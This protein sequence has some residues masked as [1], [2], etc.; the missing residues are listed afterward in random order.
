VSSIFLQVCNLGQQI[1]DIAERATRE[2]RATIVDS[3]AGTSDSELREMLLRLVRALTAGPASSLH[4]LGRGINNPA[5]I[6]ASERGA[7]LGML[8]AYGHALGVGGAASRA[9]RTFE[10]P[11]D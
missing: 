2:R 11:A 1:L 6:E 3:G 9:L 8:G 5:W 10:N 4:S 7:Q